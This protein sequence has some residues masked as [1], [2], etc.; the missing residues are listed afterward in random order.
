MKKIIYKGVLETVYY[1]KLKNGLEV[2]MYPNKAAR[3]FYLTFNVKFGSV[4]TE[5]KSDGDKRFT[6]V[7]NGTA[8]FLEHQMFQEEDGHT[9]FEKFAKLGSSVNAFTT[10]NQTCYEVVA[11]DNFKENLEYLIDYVQNPVFKSSSVQR[12]KGIIKEE[13]SMYDNTPGSVLN[14]GLE[15]NLNVKDHHKYSISGTEEDI[16]EITP[17]DLEACYDV[18]YTP[19]NMFMVLTGNFAPLEALGI[20]KSNQAKKE[21][22]E[23]KKIIRKRIHEPSYVACPYKEVNMDVA[24]PK[25]K[26]AYKFDKSKF[27]GYTLTELKVYLDLILQAKFGETSDLLEKLLEE[28]LIMWDLYPSHDVRDDYIVISFEAETDYKEEVIDLIREELKDMKLDRSEVE[29]IKKSF[30]S[31]FILHFN[32]IIAVAESIEDDILSNDKVE[33]DIMDIYKSLNVSTANAIIKEL[34]QSDETIFI[35]NNAQ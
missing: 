3:N 4:D 22:K 7:P 24:T 31:N 35:I 21:F 34:K 5:F 1:E 23:E 6:K 18:F 9:A 20:I 33:N 25:V 30:I 17:E 13:I 29:M 14:Y 28:N 10:Y 27:K 8:H 26:I 16:K 11:S 19:T 2:F 32:D 12:E 15:D